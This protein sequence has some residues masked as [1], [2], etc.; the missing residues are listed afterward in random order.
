MDLKCEQMWLLISDYV[1]GEVLAPVRADMDRHLETCTR[2]T[3]VL[4]GTKNL[5]QLYGDERM[6][7]VPLDFSPALHRRLSQQTRPERGAAFTWALSLA[8][9]GLATAAMLLFSLPRFEQPTM[10]APMSQPA[11]RAPVA[12]LVVVNDD[13]KTFHVPG[14]T[15]IH[16]KSRMI[17]VEEAMK[18]GYNPCIRCEAG[19]LHRTEGNQPLSI[20]RTPP[21]TR[22]PL[23]AK[24]DFGD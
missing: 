21:I 23:P 20:T 12:N 3:A 4:A 7:S 6:F 10:R 2:C 24:S 8:G 16:G 14:C 1:D 22:T 13:G 9:A 11:L 18:E 17:P 15:Y 5:V 19:L